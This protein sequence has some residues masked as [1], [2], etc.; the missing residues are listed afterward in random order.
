ML[1]FSVS[2]LPATFL[3]DAR[4]R[5]MAMDPSLKMLEAAATQLVEQSAGKGR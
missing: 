1:A 2:K 4:G 3:I 5:L